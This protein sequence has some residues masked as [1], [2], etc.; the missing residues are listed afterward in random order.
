M[1]QVD[2]GIFLHRLNYSDTSL[3]VQFFTR[4]KGLRRFIFK[5]G[6]KKSHQLYPMSVSEL[7]FFERKESELLNLIAADPAI[8]SDFQFNPTK[9]TIAFFLAEVVRKSIVQNDVDEP[10]FE[11][12][13]V[14]VQTLD[15][16]ESYELFPVFFLI[17]LSKIIGVHPLITDN[18]SFFN[19]DEGVIDNHDR[20]DQRVLTGPEVEL[21]KARITGAHPANVT[22]ETREKALRAM[23]DYFKTHV[24][25]FNDIT[26]YEIVKEVLHA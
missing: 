14:Q 17:D 22:R 21:I 18:G 13:K 5:G 19:L 24:P 25:G 12:L 9:S 4:S 6:K 7:T 26:S 23:L 10:F 8:P 11:F 3:I 16:T 15:A 1:K 2:Q 20:Q